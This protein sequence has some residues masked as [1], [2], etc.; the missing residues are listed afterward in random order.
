MILSPTLSGHRFERYNEGRSAKID[1][2]DRGDIE[3]N[4]I[5]TLADALAFSPG[6]NAVQSGPAGSV[7]SVFSR[8]SNSK[9]TLALFD[10]IRL[11][12]A[13]TPNGQY[14]FGQDTLGDAER[15]EVIRGPLS[16]VYGSDA[17]GGVVN[18]I[19]RVGADAPVSPYFEASAGELDSYRGLVGAAGT[20][21]ALDYNVTLEGFQT[22]GYD[23]IPS[24]MSTDTNDPDGADFLTATALGRYRLDNGLSVSGLVRVRNASSDFDTFSGGPSGFQRADD[25]NLKSGK[26]DYTVWRVG[27]RWESQDGSMTSELR[28]GQ[29][30]NERNTEDGGTITDAAEGRRDFAEWLNVWTPHQTGGLVAPSVSFGVQ[31]SPSA[32]MRPIG[33]IA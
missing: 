29:V 33:Q 22:G 5:Q 27:G 3:L 28:A 31:C 15:V 16:S 26:D 4:N 18:I 25:P 14:N 19:P 20:T 30:Y 2:V 21:N 24:R 32:T 9:H 11:N 10:G 7:T 13:S 6:V 8:G 12:D 23:E 17:I 1:V